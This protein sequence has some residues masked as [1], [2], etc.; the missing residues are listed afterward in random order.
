MWGL[1]LRSWNGGSFFSEEGLTQTPD[2]NVYTDA[3]GASGYGAYYHP[4]WFIGHWE[5]CQLLC[6]KEISKAYQELFPIVLAALLWG[7]HWLCKHILVMC[8]NEGTVTVINSCTSKSPVMAN[9]LRHLVLCSMQCNFLVR[10]KH[11]PGRN[12]PITDALSRNQVQCFSP[13]PIPE[14]LLT[15]LRH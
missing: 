5:L 11:L 6:N 8:D 10:A 2:I 7:A 3:S 1:F 9:L 15:K 13:T 4:E 12:N 14:E